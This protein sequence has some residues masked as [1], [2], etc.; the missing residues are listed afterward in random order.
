MMSHLDVQS[1]QHPVGVTKAGRCHFTTVIA[2]ALQVLDLTRGE[3]FPCVRHGLSSSGGSGSLGRA[4]EAI[5]E[6]AEQR[7]A[8]LSPA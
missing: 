2:A 6:R 8:S 7:T 3:C 1:R 5:Q 4:A